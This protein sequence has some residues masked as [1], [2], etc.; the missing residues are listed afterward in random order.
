MHVI[1]CQRTTRSCNYYCWCY[2]WRGCS[3]GGAMVRHRFF[4]TPKIRCFWVLCLM[5][6]RFVVI[7]C[8][9]FNSLASIPSPSPKEERAREYIYY[10]G[11]TCCEC[12]SS[13]APFNITASS[14][15]L[16]SSS[17]APASVDHTDNYADIPFYYLTT[18]QSSFSLFSRECCSKAPSVLLLLQLLRCAN[19][20]N[21][22]ECT[23][24]WRRKRREI[25]VGTRRR[26]QSR[27][28]CAGLRKESEW[29]SSIV[30][31]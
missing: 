6:D 9:F 31:P 1:Q 17:S 13:R 16:P 23:I 8:S 30:N 15:S 7:C 11:K 21:A 25:D 27:P 5:F 28:R 19:I 12:Q 10:V 4:V 20:T 24:F 14:S 29:K 18:N 26:L 2:R 3:I 22:Q